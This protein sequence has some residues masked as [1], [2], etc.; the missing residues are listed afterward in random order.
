M[1]PAVGQPGRVQRDRGPVV[2]P[3]AVRAV[4]QAAPLPRGRVDPAVGVDAGEGGQHLG[5]S[6][7]PSGQVSRSSLRV[8]ST[9]RHLV[10]GQPV[11]QAGVLPERL[12]RGEP[13]RRSLPAAWTRSSIAHGQLGLGRELRPRR[14][15]RRPRSGPGPRSRSRQVELAVDQRMPTA[16][17]VGQEHPQLTVVDLPGGAGVLPLHPGRAAALLDE[18]GVV[19]DEHPSHRVAGRRRRPAVS[20]RPSGRSR[21]R[22]HGPRRRPSP[23]SAAAAASHPGTPHPRARPASTRSF[24]SRPASSPR[25]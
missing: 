9:I 11:A 18:P 21:A 8:A 13:A 22:R 12:V 19:G 16:G 4:A 24:V 10:V 2:D 15:S 7:C 25:T 3:L 14:G 6:R 1:A 20:A 23:R 5:R 17:G